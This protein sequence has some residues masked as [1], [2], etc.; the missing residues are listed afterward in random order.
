MSPR[1]LIWSMEMKKGRKKSEHKEQSKKK[2]NQKSRRRLRGNGL[3]PYKAILTIN[4]GLK[5]DRLLC[6]LEGRN[7]RARID[8]VSLLLSLRNK[9]VGRENTDGQHPI[10][11]FSGAYLNPIGMT[12]GVLT[13]E[14]EETPWFRRWRNIFPSKTS[15]LTSLSFKNKNSQ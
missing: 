10:Y 3:V 11:N 1:D 13:E 8:K 15:V 9:W 7:T 6:G 2:K 5:N 14:A 4:K 12:F